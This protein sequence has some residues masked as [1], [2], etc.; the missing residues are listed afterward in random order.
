MG[1]TMISQE[2]AINNVLGGLQALIFHNMSRC[3][4]E[5]WEPT[6]IDS[7]KMDNI[8]SLTQANFLKLRAIREQFEEVITNVIVRK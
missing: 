8:I 6:T 7:D 3:A 4:D 5:Q 2:E 1:I